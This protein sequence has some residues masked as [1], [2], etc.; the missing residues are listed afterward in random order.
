MYKSRRDG[1]IDTE[2]IKFIGFIVPYPG[3]KE[4][5]NSF[6]TNK[7]WNC[8]RWIFKMIHL[9]HKMADELSRSFDWP[10]IGHLWLYPGLV[11]FWNS[12]SEPSQVPFRNSNLGGCDG[13]ENAACEEFLDGLLRC[14]TQQLHVKD[15]L[16]YKNMITN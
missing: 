6:G 4:L 8:L 2:V 15:S 13:N 12:F 11:S 7:N 10:A 1:E 14:L 9:A 5:S 3:R 16:N